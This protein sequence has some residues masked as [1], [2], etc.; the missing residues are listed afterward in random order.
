MNIFFQMFQWK[1]YHQLLFVTSQLFIFIRVLWAFL[2]VF[3]WA[4]LSFITGLDLVIQ[5][6]LNYLKITCVT[7]EKNNLVRILM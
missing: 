5:D 3:Y 1:C 7:S 6:H 4:F 2:F